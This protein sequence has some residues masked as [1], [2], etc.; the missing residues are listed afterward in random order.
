MAKLLKKPMV[1]AALLATFVLSPRVNAGT[2]RIDTSG[3]SGNYLAAEERWEH[4]GHYATAEAASAAGERLLLA[5]VAKKF[6][7]IV[8]IQNDWAMVYVPKD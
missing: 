8:S 6:R 3:G 2:L 4:G 1:A 7:V 5:G